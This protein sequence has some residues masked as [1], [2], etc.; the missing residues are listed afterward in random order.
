MQ[1]EAVAD[2]VVLAFQTALAPV[3]AR[4]SALEARVGDVAEIAKDVGPL[5]ERVA[6]VEVKPLLPGPAGADGAN[7]KDGADGKDGL[8]YQDLAV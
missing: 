1:P 3:L 4:L 2:A 6:A 8:W 7:G 5:R